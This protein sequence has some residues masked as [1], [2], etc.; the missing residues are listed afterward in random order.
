[1]SWTLPQCR[2]SHSPACGDSPGYEG[3][4]DLAFA[5]RAAFPDIMLTIDDMV[6]VGDTVAVRFT[7]KGT[8][9]GLFTEVPPTGKRITMTNIEI[10]RIS[11]EKIMEVWGE[12]DLLRVMQQLGTAKPRL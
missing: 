8:N 9:A 4:K 7:T 11:D 5:Y 10:F 6:A 1:M 3:F 12:V 2:P